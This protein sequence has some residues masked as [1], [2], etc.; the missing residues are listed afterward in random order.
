MA[1]EG[2]GAAVVRGESV[3]EMQSLMQ[4]RRVVFMS[5]RLAP[6]TRVGPCTR[7]PSATVEDRPTA[8]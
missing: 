4:A 5:L 3:G 1:D 7:Y 2:D 8:N 6:E